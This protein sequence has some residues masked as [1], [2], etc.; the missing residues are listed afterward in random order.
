MEKICTVII[1]WGG[2]SKFEDKAITMA[3]LK[4]ALETNYKDMTTTPTG[5]E[6]QQLC[7]AAPKY[8]NDDDYVDN[9]QKHILNFQAD[10]MH[11]TKH[12]GLE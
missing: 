9:I 7:L 10:D 5:P 8:G 4:H 3:Q 2:I 11:K 6:I 12:F 1:N